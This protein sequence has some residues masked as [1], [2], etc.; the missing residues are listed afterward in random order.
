MVNRYQLKSTTP[1]PKSV[2]KSKTKKNKTKQN[3]KQKKKLKKPK[4]TKANVLNH[5][6]GYLMKTN[7]C[8]P[9]NVY[10]IKKETNPKT[11]F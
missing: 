7:I 1:D 3:K 4:P 2:G 8:I 10:L 11:L 6:E 9:L 5:V